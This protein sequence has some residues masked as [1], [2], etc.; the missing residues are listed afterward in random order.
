MKFYR[1]KSALKK[2]EIILEGKFQALKI[3]LKS[4]EESLLYSENHPILN[5]VS[6]EKEKIMYILEK[7]TEINRRLKILIQV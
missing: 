7:S 1:Y 5:L 3:I 2:P 4:D 6:L